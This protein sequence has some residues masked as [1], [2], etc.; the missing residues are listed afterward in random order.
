MEAEETPERE[1]LLLIKWP[2]PGPIRALIKARRLGETPWSW[3]K[4]ASR[5]SRGQRSGLRKYEAAL[6]GMTFKPK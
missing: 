2:P 3:T 4:Q 6:W 1:A 5:E